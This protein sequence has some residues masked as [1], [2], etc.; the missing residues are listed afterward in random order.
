MRRSLIP[1]L[2][3]NAS[4]NNKSHSNFA[5]F[6]LGKIFSKQ[7]TSDFNESVALAGIFSG[8]PLSEVQAILSGFITSVLPRVKSEL[9]QDASDKSYIHPG[10]S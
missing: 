9:T 6:E 2:L 1:H 10:K 5:F 3:S 8:I 7:A 4:E